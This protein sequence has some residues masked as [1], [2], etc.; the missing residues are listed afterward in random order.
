[1]A[2]RKYG[3]AWGKARVRFLAQHPWCAMHLQRGERR[4]ATV[5]DH[6]RPHHGD[7]ALFW[8]ESNWQALCQP[9]HDAHKQRLEK[10]GKVIGCDASGI[11]VDPTHH[12][13]RRC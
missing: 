13:H 12:W 11:P 2:K 10:S 4:A 6:I 9:C 3:R 7:D 5:V 1:M 8:D